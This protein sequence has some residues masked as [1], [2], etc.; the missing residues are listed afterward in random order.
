MAEVLSQPVRDLMEVPLSL[1]KPLDG[2]GLETSGEGEKIGELYGEDQKMCCGFFFKDDGKG[3]EDMA[4][5]R[6]ALLEKRVRR[7]KE[8]Q[9]KKQQQELEQE[10]RKEEARLKAEEEQQKREDDKQR[11]DYIKNEYM[12]RKHLKQVEDM[13]VRPRHGSLKKKPRPKSMHRD[14]MESPKPPARATGTRPRGFSVSSMSLASLNL[15]NDSN[16]GDK[17]IRR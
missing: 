15:D 9:E 8:T 1:L 17:R 16:A 7:E 14:V 5:K 12:R 3:E 11:K 4:V 13:D 2:Q 10:Q 6:A